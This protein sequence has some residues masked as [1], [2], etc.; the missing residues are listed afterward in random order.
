MKKKPI[1]KLFTREFY[2]ELLPEQ[3]L[4]GIKVIPNQKII[5]DDGKDR[6]MFRI[7]IGFL[8]LV[9]S[10]TNVDYSDLD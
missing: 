3:P 2:C 4:V 7:E 9:L 6:P 8:F 5:G 1:R 10:Y